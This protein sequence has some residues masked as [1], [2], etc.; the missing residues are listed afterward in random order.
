MT[1]RVLGPDGEPLAGA[2][3]EV[4]YWTPANGR[5]TTGP[6]AAGWR[7]PNARPH[8]NTDHEGAYELRVPPAAV[9]VHVGVRADDCSPGWSSE[10]RLDD[11]GARHDGLRRFGG[12]GMAPGA[13]RR[14]RG[15]DS[16]A[17]GGTNW[18]FWSRAPQTKWDRVAL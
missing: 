4:A 18:L 2:R 16:L 11:G 15:L 10:L 8:A 3:V 12:G 14:H 7:Q 9:T 17:V 13:G 1:G 5:I 6:I